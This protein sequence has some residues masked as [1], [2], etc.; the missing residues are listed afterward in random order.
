MA[1]VTWER[2]EDGVYRREGRDGKP[3]YRAVRQAGKDPETGK[4]LQETATFN[5]S[6]L[7]N[8]LREAR[9]WRAEGA[10]EADKGPRP[11]NV[12]AKLTLREAYE[13]LHVEVGEYG[14]K[15]ENGYKPAT[16]G[17]HANAWNALLRAA[18]SLAD[19]QLRELDATTLRA[20]LDKIA[21]KE[22]KDKA[23]VLVHLIYRHFE[24]SPNPAVKRRRIGGLG[25]QR[26]EE[27]NGN[28]RYL[29][30][31]AVERLIAALPDRYRMLVRLLWRVGLRPGEALAL[32]VGQYDPATRTLTIDRAANKGIVGP[33]KTGRTRRPVLPLTIADELERHIARFSDWNDE[34]SLVFTTEAGAMVDLHNFRQRTW[35]RATREAGIPEAT[36]YD[37]RHTFCSNA[38]RAGVDLASV[39]EMA[40]HSVEVL[41]RVYVHYSE[42]GG[43]RAAARLDALIQGEEVASIG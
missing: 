16:I 25:A 18:P 10:V 6:K 1:G 9:L 11:R 28:G 43:R 27:G 35:A 7:Q 30:D 8:A 3:I 40:G 37:A 36:P 17:L 38:V 5:G 4:Y 32:T 23:R 41:A 2:V 14:P 13:K 39:A 33:T 42:E 12:A 29:E 22:I 31:G 24:V 19:R 15:N 26:D 34:G 21:G 20:A